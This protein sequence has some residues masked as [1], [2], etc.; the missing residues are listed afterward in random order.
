MYL[1]KKCPD[2]G[3]TVRMELHI[4][5]GGIPLLECPDCGTIKEDRG[6]YR[7]VSNDEA[8]KIIETREP[9]GLFVHD[10]GIEMVG[11]DNRTGDAWTEDF[12]DLYECLLWLADFDKEDE[13]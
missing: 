9:L 13:T 2:C 7:Y 11:I 5:P 3:K 4:A 12:P 6:W 8:N 1:K 10:T